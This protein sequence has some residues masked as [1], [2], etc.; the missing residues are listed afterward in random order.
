[1]T[2]VA[3]LLISMGLI[4]SQKSLARSQQRFSFHEAVT[5]RAQQIISTISDPDYQGSGE[6]FDQDNSINWQINS[7][8]GLI[9]LSLQGE[10]RNKN[11]KITLEINKSAWLSRMRYQHE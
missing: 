11:L 7:K 4:T 10:N 8:N 6:E 1:M 3:V 2:S 5:S 9:T